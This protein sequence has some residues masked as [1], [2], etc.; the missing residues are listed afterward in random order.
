MRVH[1]LRLENFR[2]HA[3]TL[4]EFPDGVVGL[5]GR[6]GAGKSTVI[7]AIAWAIYG[8]DAAR[9]T[10]DLV[11][12][13]GPGG[14]PE[15]CSVTLRFELAGTPVEVVRELAGKGLTPS[16]HVLVSGQ[17]VVAP[18]AN[19]ARDATE[20]LSRLLHMDRE[21]F[22]TSLVARQKELNALSDLTPGRRKEVVLRMLRVELVDEAIR[23]A[24][25]RKRELR[26]R[27][28]SLSHAVK[29]VPAAEEAL[30][31]T[32]ERAAERRTA[33]A[34]LAAEVQ[35]LERAVE[36]SRA[37]RDEAKAKRD[38]HEAHSSR[39]ERRRERV[40]LMD[41]QLLR[42]RAEA[43]GLADAE[44]R[45]QAM[46]PREE[47][48]HQAR[49]SLEGFEH[50]RDRHREAL[51]RRREAESLAQEAARVRALADEKRAR[52]G[53]RSRLVHEQTE[54]ERKRGERIAELRELTKTLHGAGIE[55]EQG[56]ALLTDIRSRREALAAMGPESPCPTCERALGESHALLLGKYDADVLDL[57]DRIAI[58]WERKRSSE[59]RVH[60]AET[61]LR[62]FDTRLSSLRQEAERLAQVEGEVEHL[63]R[64][65][66]EL[67]DRLGFVERAAAEASREPFHE[68]HYVKLKGDLVQLERTHEAVIH[69]RAELSRRAQLQEEV[70]ILEADLAIATA[71]LHAMEARIAELAYDRATL[72][73][74]LQAF[75]RTQDEAH[76]RRIALERA[77][78]ELASLQAE[79][80]RL[81]GELAEQRAL[82]ER[83]R[84]LQEELIHL[85]RLAGDRDSGLL[86]DFKS[87]L[88]GRIRPGLARHASELFR[89]MT[90]GR[91]SGLEI[92]DD[93]DILILEEGASYPLERFSGGEADLANLCLRIA[94]G[95]VMAE[96]TGSEVQF[97][98]LDEIFGSQ[99]EHRKRSILHALAGL[100]GRF[101]QILLITHV[102]D[103]KEGLEH[104]LVVSEAEDGSSRVV[105]A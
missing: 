23:L 89:T 72:D 80:S 60:G 85:E 34:R 58:A 52:L 101:R 105:P 50:L 62:A 15:P 18:G 26:A 12:R 6:N 74:A 10:K 59:T 40:R 33:E 25:E 79:L 42:K 43:S 2:K 39:L 22:F 95:L 28:E 91:Y 81:E 76:A 66:D 21:A 86:P 11:P 88:I 14:E 36:A 32:A 70:A 100:R 104:A 16:A 78:G 84:A 41:E 99:D 30:R 90:E 82:Q 102:E 64:R 98:A 77:R 67:Q 8:N 27:I 61:E 45:L 54:L 17:P 24:R 53:Q 63:L 44:A 48:Y 87:Q 73:A 37:R 19:S 57:E 97:L 103:V 68:E 20:Y 7:E 38:E 71:D 46:M 51:L 75:E 31:R 35:D 55:V 49:A 94:I 69:L 29:D 83:V 47:E 56:N 3:D 93:Y 65:Q 13:R 5:L 9:T 1:S 96:R 92:T 4:I